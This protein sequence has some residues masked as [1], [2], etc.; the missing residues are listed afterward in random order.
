MTGRFIFPAN[1]REHPYEE[2]PFLDSEHPF[3][4]IIMYGGST[5]NQLAW[6]RQALADGHDVNKVYTH[7]DSDHKFGFRGRPLHECIEYPPYCYPCL[8]R[9]ETIDLIRFLLENGAD[10][11]LKDRYDK[12]TP[13]DRARLWMT[14]ESTN[15]SFLQEALKMMERK[16]RSLDDEEAMACGKPPSGFLDKIKW[17][18]GMIGAKGSVGRGEQVE[19]D[20]N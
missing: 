19:N 20:K 7:P 9:A 3:H 14:K 6:A 11:R 10:P 15:L 17:Y 5:H 18:S 4:A 2:S 16:A 8:Q 1:W 13:M 12:V